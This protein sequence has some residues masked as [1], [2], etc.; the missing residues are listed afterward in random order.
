[1]LVGLLGI[2]YFLLW[3]G[4]YPVGFEVAARY[5]LPLVPVLGFTLLYWRRATS[6]ASLTVAQL[7]TV[8]ALMSIAHSVALHSTIRRYVTGVGNLSLDLDAGREWWWDIPVTPNMV[9]LLGSVAFGVLAGLLG[10]T[11]RR[12]A[13][14]APEERPSDELTYA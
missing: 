2:P 14:R 9:W 5:A 12:G 1:V 10:W 6:V 4:G 8:L 3:R 7:S 11:I 13:A